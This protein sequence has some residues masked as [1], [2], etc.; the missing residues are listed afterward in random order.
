MMTEKEMAPDSLAA[1]GANE[2]ASCDA[3]STDYTLVKDIEEALPPICEVRDV[4]NFMSMKPSA[5][6]ELCRSGALRAI[7]AGA[8]WRIPR[9][10]LLEFVIGGGVNER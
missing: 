6:R 2:Y 4:A 5:V 3:L 9:A 10:W 8:L 1:P 7:K